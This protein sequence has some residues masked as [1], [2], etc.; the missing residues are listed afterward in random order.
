MSSS[1]C[2][3]LVCRLKYLLGCLRKYFSWREMAALQVV[4]QEMPPSSECKQRR[5][6]GGGWGRGNLFKIS[7]NH[8]GVYYSFVSSQNFCTVL[9]SDTGGGDS[10]KLCRQTSFPSISNHINFSRIHIHNTPEIL[11]ILHDLSIWAAIFKETSGDLTLRPHQISRKFNLRS[12]QTELMNWL[13]RA[14]QQHFQGHFQTQ[15]ASACSLY[16]KNCCMIM[17]ITSFCALY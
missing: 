14:G 10:S 2:W 11:E 17:L 13:I 8:H 15:L 12:R 5:S 9:F 6:T 7:D 4:K 16:L 1:V 3:Y